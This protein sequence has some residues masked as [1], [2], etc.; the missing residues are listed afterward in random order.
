MTEIA[1]TQTIAFGTDGIRGNA[2]QF[3]FTP[4]ALVTFG[5]A[6]G[7]WAQ[8]KYGTQNPKFLI[9]SDTRISSPRIKDDLCKGLLAQGALVVDAHVLPTPAVYQL[10]SSDVSFHAGIVISASHNPY[11]DNG[12]KVFDARHCK[13]TAEDEQ[14]IVH[15][16]EQASDLQLSSSCS[17]EPCVKAGWPTANQSYQEAIKSRFPDLFLKNVKVILDCANGAT[18]SIAPELF[19]AL[20]ANVQVLA[21]SPD[22]ININNQCGALHPENLA[23]AVQAAQADC[24]FAFDGDG[25]R[26]VAVNKHGQVKDGDDILAL[27][28]QLA[29]YQPVSHVVGTIMTNQGFESYLKGLGKKLIRTCVG[30]KYVTAQLEKEHLPLGGE[31]SGH[32]IMKDYLDTGDGI[33]VA[34]KVLE[35][36]IAHNN[37]D[38]KTFDKYPQ[39]LINVPVVQK[40][41]LEQSPFAQIIAEHKKMLDQGRLVVRYSGTENLLRVMTEATTHRLA[42]SIADAVAYK[43]QEALR[44]F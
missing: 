43:L 21:D 32:I 18:Y 40:K 11:Q 37:W 42:S 26:V 4:D 6:L 39:I 8:K 3:P 10:I 23:K 22:G 33:L 31:A 28:L 14:E 20:G 41:D 1:Y 16:F 25:D 19:R 5:R 44:T 12:I 7:L 2:E 24:G 35:S 13:I 27:L 36:I 17:S 9:G 30:D 29:A 34:L 15:N 38:M